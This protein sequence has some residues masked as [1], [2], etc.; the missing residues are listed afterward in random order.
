MPVSTNQINY[1]PER[2]LVHGPSLPSTPQRLCSQWPEK[3]LKSLSP[4]T[5]SPPTVKSCEHTGFCACFA[6]SPL[7]A[8]HVHLPVVRALPW[9]PVPCMTGCLLCQPCPHL[10]QAPP[11]C[12]CETG[13]AI[14]EPSVWRCLE[15][16][17]SGP[18]RTEHSSGCRPGQAWA[19]GRPGEQLRGGTPVREGTQPDKEP[20]PA[21]HNPHGTKVG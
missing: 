5:S 13:T 12:S 18:S 15:A 4:V 1:C 8:A 11:R 9:S 14:W 2:D 20:S 10:P 3:P 6:Q 16:L 7:L 19:R 17:A 21:K